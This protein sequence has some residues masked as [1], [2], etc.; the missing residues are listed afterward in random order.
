MHFVNALVDS[1]LI[2]WALKAIVLDVADALK[3]EYSLERVEE[4]VFERVP[5][6]NKVDWSKQEKGH[7]GVKSHFVPDQQGQERHIIS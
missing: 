4:L 2:F 5:T 3:Q 1:V 6:K 7:E